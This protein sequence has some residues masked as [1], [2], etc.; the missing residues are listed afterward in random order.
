M[1]LKNTI[2]M[3]FRLGDYKHLGHFHPI[4]GFNYYKNALTYIL[5]SCQLQRWKIVYFCEAEDNNEVLN[6][7]NGLAEVF[8]LLTFEKAS[9]QMA[10]WEQMLLILLQTARLVGLALISIQTRT[11]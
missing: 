3:H 4:M 11:N 1:D 2:A 9:D 5:S 7:I 10:D 6:I 8:P